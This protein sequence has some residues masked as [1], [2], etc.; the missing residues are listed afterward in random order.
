MVW[1]EG[2]LIRKTAL[3][4]ELPQGLVFSFLVSSVGYDAHRYNTIIFVG[5]S[6]LYSNEFHLPVF[7]GGGGRN[8]ERFDELKTPEGL[9]FLSN[10]FYF[11]W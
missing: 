4:V 7:A 11:L 2:N 1:N 5:T 9:H 10:Y 6:R 8:K 3:T